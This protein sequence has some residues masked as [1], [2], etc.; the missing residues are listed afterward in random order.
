[1]EVGAGG[2]AWGGRVAQQLGGSRIPERRAPARQLFHLWSFVCALRFVRLAVSLIIGECTV[3][4][5]CAA[6]SRV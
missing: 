1:M 4:V 2:R 5:D 3:A 6:L